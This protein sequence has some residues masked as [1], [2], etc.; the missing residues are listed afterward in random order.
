MEEGFLEVLTPPFSLVLLSHSIF[1]RDNVVNNSS[2]HFACMVKC[3]YL[4]NLL[5][6]HI[7][8]IK[9]MVILEDISCS[10]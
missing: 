9:F 6:M 10:L 2:L 1:T 3:F 5:V 7:I 4:C 8:F